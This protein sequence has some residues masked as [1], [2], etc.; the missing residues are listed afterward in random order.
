VAAIRETARAH[1]PPR[2]TP[3]ALYVGKLA[4][5]KGTRHLLTAIERASL[6]WPLVVVGDGPDRPLV[7]RWVR[8]SGRDVTVTGWLS[9]ER[10][11]GWLANASVLVFPSLGPESLSRVLLDASA[12][13]APVAA[14]DTGGTRDIIVPGRTGL[15]SETA[16][17]LGDD[18]ARIAGDPV[19]AR[20]LGDGAR[21][22]VEAAFAADRVVERIEAVY[23]E[24]GA[25]HA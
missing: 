19:L 18:V 25:D 16:E 20:Q 4:P 14:M 8:D 24:A 11:L 1:P 2:R 3:F 5:N 10:A 22:H 23:R 21:A 17:G 6:R 9:R 12:L 7:E 15:L 13:G